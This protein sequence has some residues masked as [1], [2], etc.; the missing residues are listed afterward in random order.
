MR[1]KDLRLSPKIAYFLCLFGLL[2]ISNLSFA[3]VTGDIDSSEE[4]KRQESP[5][6]EARVVSNRAQDLMN[7]VLEDGENLSIDRLRVSNTPALNILGI[8]E[9]EISKPTTPQ[10]FGVTILES[11]S[12]AQGS[13][14]SNFVV[15]ISPFWWFPRP[16][17]TFEDYYSKT[18][19][20]EFIPESFA[21]SLGSTDVMLTDGDNEIDATRLSTGI[22]FLL[23]PG[24]PDNE[25]WEKAE[26][27]TQLQRQLRAL[28]RTHLDSCQR[29]IISE[30]LG[31]P[32]NDPRF[33]DLMNE[34]LN[35]EA[36]ATRVNTICFA[37]IG[38][39]RAEEDPEDTEGDDASINTERDRQS[40]SQNWKTTIINLR[41]SLD[42]YKREYCSSQSITRLVTG[43]AI[44]SQRELCSTVI[45]RIKLVNEIISTADSKEINEN[46]IFF[47][48]SIKR[49]CTGAIFTNLQENKRQLDSLISDCSTDLL[50]V[51]DQLETFDLL[52]SIEAQPIQKMEEEIQSILTKLKV[53]AADIEE[54]DLNREGFQLRFDSAGAFDFIDDSI[55]SIDFAKAAAWLTASYQP[56]GLM[57]DFTFLGIGRYT[58]DDIGDNG[59]NLVDLGASFLITPNQGPVN[60]QIEYIARFG[61]RRD[62]R[63]VGVLEYRINDTYSVFASYGQTFDD[64]FNGDSDLV[65][66]FGI[67]FGLGEGPVISEISAA[68]SESENA[69]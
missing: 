58:F 3:Q 65:S 32:E 50:T 60:F 49:N 54:L 39:E 17:L 16:N 59:E 56:T 29:K 22:S 28:L 11:V 34:L 51:S 26:E 52:L 64:S 43:D 35:D 61:D 48:D 27:V 63:L 20:G 25:L 42:W 8:S 10:A 4:E 19:F 30:K 21:I 66:I 36:E 44:V 24:K 9:R 2:S 37:Q 6:L 12:S 57:D 53:L 1:L 62:D 23:D 46:E 41:T 67:N 69:R 13:F 31:I 5:E 40:V 18:G 45:N 14:P 15:E 47:L 55:S 38:V 33:V 7:T 68:A